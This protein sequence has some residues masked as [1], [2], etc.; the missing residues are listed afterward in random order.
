VSAFTV[1]PVTDYPVK[2]RVFLGFSRP[3][4]FCAIPSCRAAQQNKVLTDWLVDL[5]NWRYWWCHLLMKTRIKN[6]RIPIILQR[7]P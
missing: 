3:M 1:Y 2:H 7:Q 5:F 6:S 4:L